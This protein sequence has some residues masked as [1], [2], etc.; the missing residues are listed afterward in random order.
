MRTELVN[1]LLEAGIID[2]NAAKHAEEH[3]LG[4]ALV[5]RLLDLG[6]GCEHDVYKVIKNKLK[7]AVVT[8][9][10]MMNINPDVIKLI[11]IGMI[12]R[13]H[14]LP[15]H[16]DSA[17]IH[18][19]VFDPTQDTCL[20]EICFFTTLRIIPY[21]ALASDLTKALNKHFDLKLPEQFKHKKIANTTEQ[22]TEQKKENLPP[23]P[24]VPLPNIPLP[25]VGDEDIFDFRDISN[26]NIDINAFANRN[27][28]TQ[29]KEQNSEQK[30]AKVNSVDLTLI[31]TAT[32]K[33][34]IVDCTIQ[35]LRSLAHSGL[36]FFVK[37][38]DMIAIKGFGEH[39]E[40]NIQNYKISLSAP[41]MFQWGFENKK[42]YMG[43]PQG[44][45]I[46][47]MFFKQIGGLIPEKIAVVPALIE[48]EVFASI[49]CE[50]PLSIDEIKRVAS[51]MAKSFENLLNSV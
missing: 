48:D 23:L 47:D 33:N 15:F 5:E 40:N 18:I 38:D 17:N 42:E 39:I 26:L 16:A 11:P 34:E 22:K 20:N 12:E 43:K 10:E 19:A 4:S 50:N 1:N 25:K 31:Q 8:A 7:L 2:E 51:A 29:I 27:I 37:N 28:P 32:T 44:G 24:N 45:Y 49:Y 30:V 36:I 41:N 3:T 6:Y 21:G 35:V 14:F 9:D 13:H 46:N